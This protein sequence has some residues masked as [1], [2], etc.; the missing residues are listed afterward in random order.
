MSS[1]IIST[2][3]PGMEEQLAP[4]LAEALGYQYL[5]PEY[6]DK[7]AE[8]FRVSK[9]RLAKALAGEASSWAT[10]GRSLQLYLGIVK[11]AVWEKFLSDN[12]VCE[13]LAAHLYIRDISH[14]LMV[15]ILTDT[16]LAINRI[17]VEK[18]ITPKKARKILDKRV[19]RRRHWSKRNFGLDEFDPSI[20]DMVLSL[21]QIEEEKAVE[22]IKD[23]AGYRKFQPMTYSLQCTKNGALAARIEASLLPEHPRIKVHVQDGAVI[24]EP[25]SLRAGKGKQADMLKEKTYKIPGVEY[26]EV[27]PGKNFINRAGNFS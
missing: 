18:A 16:K 1:I 15:R 4:K 10:S 6:L 8:D 7:V 5:G 3:F 22:V 9:G 26:V 19:H 11:T 20:Y 27:H 13:G 24:L 23:M 25:G 14:V 17:A 12:I 21:S 2:D